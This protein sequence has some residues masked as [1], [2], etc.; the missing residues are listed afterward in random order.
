M[1][2]SLWKL[3]GM[4]IGRWKIEKLKL[5]KKG[6]KGG[7]KLV[8]SDKKTQLS[9]NIMVWNIVWSVFWSWFGKLK[10][11]LKSA[12]FCP[13]LPLF[14]PISVKN[15]PEIQKIRLSL[16]YDNVIW[17]ILCFS[18]YEGSLLA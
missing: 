11:E 4:I 13:F 7:Q 17:C 3:A 2:G 1:V 6:V 16:L 12:H 5:T 8:K 14:V 10:R 18:P 15:D 9:S